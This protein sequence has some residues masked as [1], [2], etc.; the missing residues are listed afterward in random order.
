LD[1]LPLKERDSYLYVKYG[2]LDVQDSA[3]VLTDSKGV[4]LQV[5][6]G[7]LTVL[8]I[9][10]G[11]TV[12]HAAVAACADAGCLL[13]WCGEGGVRLYAAGLMGGARSDKLMRQFAISSDPRRR[14]D[15]VRE[16]YRRRFGEQAPDRRSVDQLRGIEGG[17][18]KQ[19]YAD[20]ARE[21]KVLWNGREYDPGRWSKAD[22]INRA[23]SA[24]NACLYALTEAAILAA[25]YSPAVGFIH[26][27]KP[28]AFVYD[29][30][31]LY[32]FTT[33]VPL[34]FRVT[35]ASPLEVEGRVRRELR[36]MF[37]REKTLQRIVPDMEEVLDA[38][39]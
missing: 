38:G 19:A 4:R 9:E 17:R 34:A 16:M 24:A 3:V 20:L 11:T 36:D 37:R 8:M 39:D 33:T 25:G 22:P 18:V 35:A 2:E 29:I 5:P 12:T 13:V 1:R 27:G 21:H 23:I 28:L 31:D 6:V 10:P 30:A 32:K 15:V 14:L 26:S 7:G